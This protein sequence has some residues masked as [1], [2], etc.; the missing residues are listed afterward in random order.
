MA[1]YLR[2]VEEK[3]GELLSLWSDDDKGEPAPEV[4]IP[5]H[6]SRVT[7]TAKTLSR[8]SALAQT[9]SRVRGQL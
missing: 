2:S 8:V 7:T 3:G 1:L 5:F 6:F 9:H 4:V